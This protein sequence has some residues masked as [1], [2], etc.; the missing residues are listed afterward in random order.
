MNDREACEHLEKVRN[1]IQGFETPYGLELLSTVHL[2]GERE[3]RV[4]SILPDYHERK[5]WLQK[6]GVRMDL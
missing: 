6:Y 3:A 2:G 4:A 1:I 5:E